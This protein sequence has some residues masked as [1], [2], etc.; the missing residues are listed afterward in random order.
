MVG[1]ELQTTENKKRRISKADRK[2]R[3]EA[4]TKTAT[5]TMT[6][7]IGDIIPTA[8]VDLRIS[9]VMSAKANKFA[10][11]R[12]AMQENKKLSQDM[13]QQPVVV[14][15][16]SPIRSPARSPSMS[17]HRSFNMEEKLS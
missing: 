7:N 14:N 16:S 12:R 2:Q 11:A 15:Q 13:V 1:E 8:V 17:P 5:T 10:E 4:A 6:I 3:R 9:P